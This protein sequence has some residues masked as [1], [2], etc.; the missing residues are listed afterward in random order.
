MADESQNVSTKEMAVVLHYVDKYGH[1]IEL[2]LRILHVNDIIATTL[3]VT[4]GVIFA[5][6]GL[7]ISKL[8]R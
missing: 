4:I 3:K 6:H 7:S 1:V 5:T 8:L 2:F